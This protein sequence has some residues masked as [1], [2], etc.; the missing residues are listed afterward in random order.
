M[1][2]L[3]SHIS[4]ILALSSIM[5]SIF[6]FRVFSNIVQKYESK[7]INNYAIIIVSERPIN[8]LFIPNIKSI[9]PIDISK[10]IDKLKKTYKNIDFSGIKLPYFYKIQLNY[11]PSPSQ[12]N[13]LKKN[14]K[15]IP[16][17]KKVM[18]YSSTQKKIYN[19]LFLL[20]RIS[21]IAMILIGI[22]GFL[23]II[24]QLEVW[25]LMHSER[26]YIMELFGAPF[27]FRG[28]A[29]FKIA[30]IDSIISL[31]LST[32]LILYITNNERF[33]QLINEL[34]INFEINYFKEF[35]FLFTI[36][37]IISLSSSIIVISAGKK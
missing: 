6:L 17:I 24:K 34:E 21:N 7:I 16:F 23:L 26:M 20:K 1:N 32:S 22:L 18:T 37:I 3:K 25:K 12:L 19:L 31:F 9:T 11:L 10:E 14:L 15:A 28:A 36:G 4:L 33:I 29:L 8:Q 35:I 5:I 13:E 27:W 30:F 2:S